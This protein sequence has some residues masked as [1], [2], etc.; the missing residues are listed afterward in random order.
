M[1]NG[2]KLIVRLALGGLLLYAS[3]GKVT[4]AEVFATALS[5]YRML[6]SEMIFL[7][8]LAMPWLELLIGLLLI[9]GI[10]KSTSAFMTAVLF[11]VFTLAVA[12]AMVR[13]IDISCGCFDL[14][15]SEDRIG[16]LT[17]IRNLFLFTCS[18]FIMTG[19]KQNKDPVRTG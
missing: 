14:T 11:L 13:G 17:L 5:N 15:S 3:V 16:A 9:T 1:R 18:L 6:P 12:Q 19:P 4:H 10:W 8:S 7:G 2:W